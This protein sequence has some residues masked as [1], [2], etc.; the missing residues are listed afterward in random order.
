MVVTSF[1]NCVDIGEFGSVQSSKWLIKADIF[2]LV[3]LKQ[4]TKGKVIIHYT[5][6]LR[7][8]TPT[9]EFQVASFCV[10]VCFDLS[11]S[12]LYFSL[13]H[14]ENMR[15]FVKI[16][17]RHVFIRSR[18][19]YVLLWHSKITFAQFPELTRLK[20]KHTHVYAF[21][22]IRRLNVWMIFSIV[23]VLFKCEL[24]VALLDLKRKTLC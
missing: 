11:N 13:L 12:L 8:L 16:L 17:P 3:F 2:D 9:F 7:L 21:C 15:I 24:C 5:N 4:T 14:S 19:V 20:Y 6:L 22:L 1:V 18:N 23:F 10:C